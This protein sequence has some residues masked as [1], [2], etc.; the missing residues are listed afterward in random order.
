MS[1]PICLHLLMPDQRPK[2]ASPEAMTAFHT[3]EY[4]NFLSRVTPET[5]MEL[6]YHQTRCEEIQNMHVLLLLTWRR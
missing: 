4:I 3:D 6:T 1:P 2:R 5:H